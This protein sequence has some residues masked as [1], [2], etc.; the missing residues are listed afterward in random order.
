MRTIS[1]VT[2]SL[3]VVV[4]YGFYQLQFQ[5]EES[6]DK[7][8]A[9]GRQIDLDEKTIKILQAEWAL[10]SSPKRLQQL[11]NKF[12]ELAPI[13]PAQIRTVDELAV[14]KDGV[15]GAAF[16]EPGEAK[17]APPVS[18][19]DVPPPHEPQSVHSPMVPAVP[20]V[21]RGMTP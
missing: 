7:A 15:E 10:L 17:P 2:F 12:L 5:V 8:S 6:Q 4:S 9:L 14:R 16:R 3:M 20:V 18:V 11:S 21:N 13:D 1:V 19:A